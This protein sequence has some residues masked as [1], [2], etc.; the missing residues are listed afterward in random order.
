MR[1][2]FAPRILILVV[3]AAAGVGTALAVGGPILKVSHNSQLGAIVV[4]AKGMTLYHLTSEHG[5]VACTGTCA[6]FW[7]PV[8]WAGKGKPTLGAGPV[9]EF[10]RVRCINRVIGQRS[11]RL[12]F[13]QL[14]TRQSLRSFLL[15]RPSFRGP[16]LS[17][18]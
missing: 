14:L 5:K 16:W 9:E 2:R 15:H 3:L 8:M 1:K 12:Q 6:T 17:A 18:R 13:R 10:R 4:D 7:P 11:Q